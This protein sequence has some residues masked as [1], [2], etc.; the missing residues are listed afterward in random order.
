MMSEGQNEARL[1][2][3]FRSK[4]QV[5]E[6][7]IAQTKAWSWSVR[8][9]QPTLGAGIL[10]LNRH[11]ECFAQ[12]RGDE[13]A[14]LGELIGFVEKSL[15]AAFAY[16]IVNYLMLMMVDHQVHFHVIPRYAAAR[17]FAGLDWADN[18]WPSLPALAERQHVDQPGI[19]GAICQALRAA[20]QG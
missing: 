20:N 11:A 3:E 2:A 9:A 16:D 4:F 7:L 14:E 19:T 15:R 17:R 1:L 13:M 6:L 12:V 18:G 8:P 10:S 5:E